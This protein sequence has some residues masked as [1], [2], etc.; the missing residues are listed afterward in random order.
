LGMSES[1]RSFSV[2]SR[3]CAMLAILAILRCDF[4]PALAFAKRA[5]EQGEAH[6]CPSTV[7]HHALAV[8]LHA[9]GELDEAL[10]A[11]RKTLEVARM[12]GEVTSCVALLGNLSNLLLES[13]QYD[14]AKV[15]LME[16]LHLARALSLEKGEAHVLINLITVETMRGEFSSIKE[17]FERTEHLIKDGTPVEGGLHLWGAQAVAFAVNGEVSEAKDALEQMKRAIPEKV[18]ENTKRMVSVVGAHVQLSV[19]EAASTDERTAGFGSVRR[20]LKSL[21]D[22]PNNSPSVRVLLLFL[23][24][25]LLELGDQGKGLAISSDGSWFSLPRTARVQVRSR[26]TQRVLLALGKARLEQAGEGL[27]IEE[28]LKFGWPDENVVATAGANRVYVVISQLRKAGL[29]EILMKRAG[30]YLLDPEFGL[31]IE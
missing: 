26:R 30:G 2:M 15:E 28:L 5:V 10:P 19:A 4:E 23:G 21:G 8:A 20:T 11:Y 6:G 27:T 14:Q 9:A 13:R 29:S 16:A 31:M 18:S 24:D 3:A 7:A 17:Y 1:S 25:R 22:S 12:H